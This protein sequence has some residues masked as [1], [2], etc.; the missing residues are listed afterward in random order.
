MRT[1]Y[2]VSTPL[3][4]RGPEEGTKVSFFELFFDLVFVFAVTQLSHRLLDHQTPGGALQVVLLLLAVWCGWIY[5][6]W[7]TNWFDPDHPVVRATLTAQM[8]AALLMSAGIPQAFEGRGWWFAFGYV[9]FQLVRTSVVVW[10]TR[11]SEFGRNFQRIYVWL[12]VASVFWVAGAFVDDGW[13]VLLWIVAV[14]IDW[15][16]PA[17]RYIVPGLGRSTLA[18]WS[19]IDGSHMAER[20]QLFVIIALGESVLV[21]GMTFADIGH[22]A[23]GALALAF[24][25]LGSVAMWWIYFDRTAEAAAEAIAQSA[26]RGRLG[27]DA[28]TY[29]HIPM[30]AG[31]IVAAVSDELVIAHPSGHTPAGTAAMLLGGPAL[32]LAGH[33]LF[34]RAVFGRWSRPHVAALVAL[35]A[36]IPATAAL[37]PLAVSGADFA[38]LAAVAMPS[39]MTRDVRR[40]HVTGHSGGR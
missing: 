19:S 13:R 10:L 28:Y 32:F 4:S 38:I 23:A 11:A 26:D 5:T 8:L 40:V 33:L 39:R 35:A 21:T 25:F 29:L 3:R 1:F 14:C 18:D 24:G 31:V 15:S 2:G 22:G 27:R 6:T 7:T 17:S 16:G 9:A 30:I 36:L 37:P 20:C 34:K 12:L